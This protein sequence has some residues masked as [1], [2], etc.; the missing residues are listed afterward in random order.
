[1]KKV[2]ILL[3]LIIL[4]AGCGGKKSANNIEKNCECEIIVIQGPCELEKDQTVKLRAI[5][6]NSES[7]K[8][9][10]FVNIAPNWFVDNNN[11]VEVKEIKKDYIKLRALRKGECKL[12]AVLGK[13]IAEIKLVVK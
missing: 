9:N 4:L 13:A 3:I 11:V 5:A 10:D 8:L 12:K 7:E 1:M 6:Y 2:L